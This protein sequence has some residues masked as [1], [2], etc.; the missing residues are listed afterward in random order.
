M[1]AYAPIHTHTC[2]C[3]THTCMQVNTLHMYTTHTYTIKLYWN[4]NKNFAKICYISL[5][6]KVFKSVITTTFKCDELLGE[7]RRH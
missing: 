6:I 1:C 5:W 4:E 7:R 3:I 2:I